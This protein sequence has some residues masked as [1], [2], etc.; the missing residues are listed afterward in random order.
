MMFRLA[1][2]YFL[3]LL[4]IVPATLWYSRR[5]AKVPAIACADTGSLARISSPSMLWLSKLVPVVFQIALVLMIVAQARPQWGTR[6]MS[7]DTEGINIMLA[8]DLSESMAALDFK[9]NGQVINRLEAIKK[10]VQRFIAGRNGDRIGMVV[11]GSQAY[12]Q[13][14]LTRDYT[15]IVTMLERLKIGSAGR[16]TAIGDALGIALK[17]LEDIKSRSNV[18][19]LLTDGSSNS[20]EFEPLAAAAIARE[21]GVKVYTVGVGSKGRAPFLINDPV[22]GKRYVYQ[23]VNIDETTLQEIAD[24]TGG[25]YFRAK[26]MDGLKEI[27]ATIDKMEKTTVKVDAFAEYKDLYPYLL[28]AAF[29]LLGVWVVLKNTRFLRIP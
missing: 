14:P 24:E 25:R 9:H 12:T 23:T 6:R 15:A 2:P 10:V 21:T 1:S 18:I 8:V 16:S 13:L 26:D 20:G 11:F 7:M 28:L 17:R 29:G 3:F 27:Y 22:F 5:R 19:I 4:A